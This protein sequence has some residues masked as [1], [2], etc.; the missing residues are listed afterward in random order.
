MIRAIGIS[1]L[2]TFTSVL[3]S[4]TAWAQDIGQPAI[5][6]YDPGVASWRPAFPG[7]LV[8]VQGNNFAMGET[9]GNYNN[10]TAEVIFLAEENEIKLQTFVEDPATLYF[11]V[12]IEA[13][14]GSQSFYIKNGADL[15]D[16]D[17]APSPTRALFVDCD[18][19]NLGPQS[20]RPELD[21]IDPE[22]IRPGDLITLSGSGFTFSG[23]VHLDQ[24]II[25]EV[26]WIS[27]K[28]VQ[29]TLPLDTPCGIQHAVRF[30]NRVLHYPSQG[31]TFPAS[32]DQLFFTVGCGTSSRSPDRTVR[33]IDINGDCL[34][35]DE[36][37]F[38]AVDSWVQG[39]ILDQLLFNAIDVWIGEADLCEQLTPLLASPLLRSQHVEVDALR[40]RNAIY[41]SPQDVTQ[42]VQIEVFT[43]TGTPVISLFSRGRGVLWRF[44]HFDGSQIANGVYLYRATSQNSF[45]QVLTSELRKLIVLR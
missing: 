13:P 6:N 40:V 43:M 23:V 1:A 45:G 16:N 10:V 32:S 34:L 31:S 21:M 26:E 41:F 7:E 30:E 42:N 19:D 27:D 22:L 39:V 15:P 38:A 9:F 37:F 5:I 33:D 24:Q 11:L 36:E 4:V 28:R 12:P 8:E 29:F 2:F 3:F 18:E 14:C 25:E 17:S 20:S 44:N 35:N